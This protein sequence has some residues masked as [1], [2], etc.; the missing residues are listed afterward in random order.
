MNLHPAFKGSLRSLTIWVSGIMGT[1]A[2][3]VP[4]FTPDTLTSLGFQPHTVKV[5]GVVGAVVMVLCR[6]VTTQSLAEKGLSPEKPA[7]EHAT[8]DPPPTDTH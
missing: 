5:M 3:V 4:I 1:L 6:S 7:D 8:A 2:L